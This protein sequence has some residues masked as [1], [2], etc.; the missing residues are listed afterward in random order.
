MTAL[1]AAF[2]DTLTQVLR[3]VAS[4]STECSPAAI[5]EIALACPHLAGKQDTP[6]SELYSETQ[7]ALAALYKV[8]CVIAAA[9]KINVEDADGVDVRDPRSMVS[10]P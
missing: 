10:R 7:S 4:A 3:E 5:L 9:E 2:A 8:I 6:R 1:K